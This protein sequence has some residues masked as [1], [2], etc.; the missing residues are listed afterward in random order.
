MTEKRHIPEGGRRKKGN[1]IK[2]KRS[3]KK[4]VLRSDREPIRLNRFISQA[5]ICTRR[6]ADALIANGEITV[7]G[8][9]VTELGI[10]VA[11]SDR[12]VYAGKRLNPEVLR[13]V[14]LNKPKDHITS[15]RDEKDKRNVIR[16]IR[17][18]TKEKVLPIGFLDRNTTG[19]LL[20]TNDQVLKETL[21]HK[22]HGA[23]QL[24]HVVLDRSLQKEHLAELITGVGLDDG[25]VKADEV[26]YVGRKRTEVG[27]R[28]IRVKTVSCAECSNILVTVS[29]NWIGSCSQASVRKKLNGAAGVT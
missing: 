4:S 22:L 10:K 20:F 5:G 11:P 8:K 9:V 12:I 26:S 28:S 7:N 14:L 23:E 6:E 17:G 2:G 25:I 19:L 27:L 21:T 1:F 3:N 16:L 29:S 24:Y 18:A 13:Y 15:S